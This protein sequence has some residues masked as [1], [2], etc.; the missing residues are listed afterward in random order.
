MIILVIV[1]QRRDRTRGLD[2][3]A[4]TERQFSIDNLLVRIHYIIV[5]IK[6][7]GLASWEFEFPF[8]GSVTSTFLELHPHHDRMTRHTFVFASGWMDRGTCHRKRALICIFRVQRKLQHELFSITSKAL[9][10]L[11]KINLCSDVHYQN[12]SNQNPF[13]CRWFGVYD[14]GSFGDCVCARD[15]AGPLGTGC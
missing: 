8:P 12:A 15:L 2:A 5:M 13:P 7:T 14:S 11:V 1:K 3:P 4:T 9:V 10:L 6:W